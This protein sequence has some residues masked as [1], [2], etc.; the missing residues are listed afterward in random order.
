MRRR[1]LGL[2]LIA[3]S[4]CGPRREEVALNELC[5]VG[6]YQ[7]D[8]RMVF[9]EGASVRLVAQ[10]TLSPCRPICDTIVERSCDFTREGN[11]FRLRGRVAVDVECRGDIRLPACG[12]HAVECTTGPLGPGE[13]TVTDG[14]R[15]MAFRVPST[16]DFQQ[17]CTAATR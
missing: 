11:T 16:V 4:G 8:A 9:R 17:N 12:I 14:A 7:Q 10:N 5:A 3:L 15:S 2:A 1:T 13:Y 6:E